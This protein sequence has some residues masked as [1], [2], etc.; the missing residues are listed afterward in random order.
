M[1]CNVLII[2]CLLLLFIC[3]NTH[4]QLFESY[5]LFEDNFNQDTSELWCVKSGDWIIENGQYLQK[6]IHSETLSVLDD[7]AWGDIIARFKVKL[8]EGEMAKIFFRYSGESYFVLELAEDKKHSSLRSFIKGKE[9]LLADV[10]FGMDDDFHFVLIQ[11][12]DNRIKVWI[13][14]RNYVSLS[15]EVF[16]TGSIALGTKKGIAWFDDIEVYKAK[17]DNE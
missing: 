6:N 11:S 16:G 7:N 8:I 5:K 15:I 1:G 10:D 12:I 14:S 9:T 13:D 17:F 3:N 4:G 2:K